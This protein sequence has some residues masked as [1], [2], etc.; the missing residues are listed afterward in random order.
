MKLTDYNSIIIL[1]EM[2]RRD[3]ASLLLDPSFLIN[4]HILLYSNKSLSVI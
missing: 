3:F 2:K 4:I 1:S